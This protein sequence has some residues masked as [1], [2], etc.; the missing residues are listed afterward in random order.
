M[1]IVAISDIHGVDFADDVPFCDILLIAGDI[2]PFK[3]D[4]GFYEQRGWFQ[5]DFVKNHLRR[6]R[7]K[8]KHVVFVA[9]NH[10]TYLGESYISDSNGAIRSI[11]PKDVHYLCNDSVVIN[12]VKIYGSPWVNLPKWANMGPPVWNF[13]GGEDHLRE[14]YSKMPNDVDIVLSHG[15]AFGFCDIILDD[16]I[17][18]RNLLMWKSPPDRL[19]SMAFRQR[20]LDGV[21]AKYV[22]S[23][24]IHSA[25]HKY[26]I[27][28]EDLSQPGI[29]F[30]CAS[31]L[32]EQYRPG[33][34]KP[35]V[36]DWK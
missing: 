4:H 2:S 35:L 10:D 16:V 20:L 30:A 5:D 24:H 21:K 36:I 7:Y 13:A 8:A 31:V 25:D 12:G 26:Q 15:P 1:K 22:I 34:Y 3:G 29:R 17:N 6:Y 19:G 11:L 23:G 18:E 32:N 33:D 14:I 28:K 9:G 27:L